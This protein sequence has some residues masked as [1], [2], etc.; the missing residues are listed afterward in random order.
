MQEK[1]ICTIDQLKAYLKST[2]SEKRYRHVMGVAET[3]EKVL[4][5]YSCQNYVPSW[6]GISAGTFV[7]LAHDISR[8]MPPEQW[9]QVCK[10]SK[11]DCSDEE[12]QTPV[13]L[14]GYVSAVIIKNMFPGVPDSWLR[15]ISI[16]TLGDKDMDDLAMALFIADFIEPN[17]GYLTDD[18]RKVYLDCKSIQLCA[19]T[20]LCDN[21]KHQM[22]KGSFIPK[23]SL[24]MKE[25]LENK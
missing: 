12:I 7:G 4:K 10:D 11:I 14:H 3:T 24:Y 9:I 21:I 16:H 13:L 15:A 20:I 19:Y 5:H 22:D 23:K 8:E 1:N 6:N 17:R 25:Y 18:Q 2:L